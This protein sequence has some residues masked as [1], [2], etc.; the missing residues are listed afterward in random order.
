MSAFLLAGLERAVELGDRDH[1][2]LEALRA[3][4]GHD[5]H[6]VVVLGL[7]RGEPL[8]LVAL[9]RL[10]R[11]DEERPEVPALVPLELC[12][13]P[14]QLSHVRHAP[15]RLALREQ[16]EVVA[17]RRSSP[18][19]PGRR[20]AGAAPLPGGPRASRRNRASLAASAVFDLLEPLRLGE[21]V[22]RLVRPVARRS[23]SSSAGQTCPP[24]AAARRSQSVSGVTPTA[25]Q[26][27]APKSISSS[28]GF[29]TTPRR[30]RM[31]STCCC[32]Q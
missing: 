11:L 9:G 10:G 15:R 31:S 29:A 2:E 26:A 17:R 23:R 24:P 12:R 27:S 6:A 28:S 3:V 22:V 21:L 1:R 8:A 19:R 18:A 20:A 13:D 4:H 32:D 7:D 14:H 30:R 25:G 5:P 16:R